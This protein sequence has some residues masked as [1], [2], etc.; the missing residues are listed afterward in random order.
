MGVLADAG[1]DFVHHYTPLHYLP[2]I[3]RDRALLGKPTLA[4]RGFPK[5][6]LR[7]KSRD[8]D[9]GRGFG[10][11]AFLTLER[12]PKIVKA[13]LKGGFPHIGIAI[14]S[15]AV[16]AATF[17]LCRYNV[18]MTR[19][20]RRN[21][22]LGSPECDSNG[23]YYGEHQIP[24]AR[25]TSDKAAL[26]EAHYGHSMIEV[27]IHGDQPLPDATVVQTFS[28]EDRAIA[29]HV[30]ETVKVPWKVDLLPPPGPYNRKATYASKVDEF[31]EKAL[32]DPDWRGNGL[33]FD[34][35]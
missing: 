3:A 31:V 15:D 32:S 9:V 26:L 14:P 5:S 4:S 34:K 8:H 21:G 6:H 29:L 28:Q 12:E 2:F 22:K 25:T 27:L 19:Y 33:E 30:L 24:V 1:V 11:Y 20:L 7:S 35:V 17:D 16:E 10:A 13:K 23:R 18:A